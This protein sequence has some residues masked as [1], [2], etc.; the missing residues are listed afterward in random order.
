MKVG[1]SPL[2]FSDIEEIGDFIGIANP[3]RAETFV[4]E[5]F[6]EC[7]KIGRSP[8]AYPARDELQ[9]GLRL[10]AFGRYLI[11]FRID[12]DQ[13]TIARVLHSAR[14]IPALFNPQD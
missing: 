4:E 10:C 1:L 14:N 7:H 2:A 13:V 3:L 6:Q 5:L 8:N 9:P 11:F 12:D